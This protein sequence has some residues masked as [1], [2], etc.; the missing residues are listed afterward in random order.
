MPRRRA[1][2]SLLVPLAVVL[3]GCS[4]GEEPAAADAARSFLA[5]V[6]SDP[7]RACD[8]LAPRTF[9]HLA[10]DGDGEC[11]KGLDDSEPPPGGDVRGATVAG[12]SAQ[13]VLG[14]QVVFLARFDVGWR[15]TAAGCER[16]STDAA[17]PYHC[18]VEGD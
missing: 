16:Q 14:D 6:R 7:A 2:P 11:T 5:L 8:L 4:A 9:E 18:T 15:V 12:R 1:V 10:E 13:V 3:G 17:V